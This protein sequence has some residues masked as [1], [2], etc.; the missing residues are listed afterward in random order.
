MLIKRAPDIKSSEITPKKLY[1]NR[2]E[3]I[4]AAGAAAGAV[5][6]VGILSKGAAVLHAVQ[7]AAHGRKLLNIKKGFSNTNGEPT[8]SWEQITTYNNFYEFGVDKTDPA[9]NARNFKTDGWMVTVDGECAKKGKY[10]I[11]DVLKGETIEERV[12]RMR[13]VEAWSMVVPWA[14]IPLA[15]F[16][17][18]CEPTGK[19]NFVKFTTVLDPKQMPGQRGLGTGIDYPYVEGLRMDEAM[20]PLSLLVVGLYGEALPNQDGAPIRLIV[21]WKYGFKGAKS[22]V[23]IEFTEKQPLNTWQRTAPNEYGFYANVNPS[24]N[25]PRW[26]QARERRIGEFLMR[27]TLMFNGYGDQVESLY[28]NLDLRKNF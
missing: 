7:P 13:C 18:R 20:N 10:S 11:D 16:V 4:R 3:F 27:P 15:N 23:K 22:I 8:N 6:G 25:H 21:P 5:T 14:G 26:S 9:D 1:L 28:K 24:V 19:A 12:Y 2:R 17:K